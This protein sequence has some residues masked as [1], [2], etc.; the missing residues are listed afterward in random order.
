MLQTAR[1]FV[2]VIFN[3]NQQ[4]TIFAS[5][6]ASTSTSISFILIAISLVNVLNT[7]S[8]TSSISIN[9]ALT[10]LNNDY[11]TSL[12]H[13]KLIIDFIVQKIRLFTFLNF[14]SL[15]EQ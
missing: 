10:L 8:D 9:N 3:Q 11:T 1:N 13:D 7:N 14:I 6:F 15:N 5:A 2:V 4:Y 12:D